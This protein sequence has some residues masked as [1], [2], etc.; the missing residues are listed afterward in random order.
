MISA[1]VKS[2]FILA[3]LISLGA[4]S[5]SNS[6]PAEAPPV[7]TPPEPEPEPAPVP[8]EELYV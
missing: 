7:A 5:D 1:A 4:C 6:N 2:F 8:F 3:M